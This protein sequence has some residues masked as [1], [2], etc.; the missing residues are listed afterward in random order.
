MSAG[1]TG[2][3]ADRR[4]CAYAPPPV[5]IC[6]GAD[7]SLAAP[8][9]PSLMPRM[10]SRWFLGPE[11]APG[12]LPAEWRDP[13]LRWNN[14]PARIHETP[15]GAPRQA[16]SLGLL[17][18]PS[19]ASPSVSSERVV[20]PVLPRPS[21]VAPAGLRPR[22]SRAPRNGRDREEAPFPRP[23]HPPR[24]RDHEQPETPLSA[25]RGRTPR[26]CP[27]RLDRGAPVLL[28]FSPV[29]YSSW[30]ARPDRIIGKAPPQGTLYVPA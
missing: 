16:K 26:R 9:D 27:G 8:P 11:G 18:L 19:A 1:R 13:L 14:P 4:R 15:P 21:A 12:F 6:A 7:Q 3:Y 10:P 20:P 23:V 29:W 5:W 17:S 2:E 25:L 28:D 22:P 24:R 30:S